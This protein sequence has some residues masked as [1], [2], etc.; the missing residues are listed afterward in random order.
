MPPGG[1]GPRTVSGSSSRP[2]SRSSRSAPHGPARFRSARARSAARS[3][4]G[5]ARSS[6]PRA[7]PPRTAGRS[8][9]G[10]RSC[11]PATGFPAPTHSS[12]SRAGPAARRSPGRSACRSS[13]RRR[14]R[15]ATSSFVDQRGTG[16]SNRLDCPLPK[17]PLGTEANAIRAYVKACLARFDA[18]V[19]QYTTAPA[20]EDVAEVVRAL[21]YEQVDVYGISYGATA[22]QYLLAQHPELVRTAI[23]DGGT[24]LDVPI[25]ELW[26]PNGERSLRS[27][28][29]RCA[30]SP[31]CARAY[32]R[33]RRE[34]FEMMATLR[35][36][37]VRASG[38]VIR[39][40]EA[41]GALQS[42][43]RTPAGAARIPWIAHRAALGDWDP[44]A[45][46]MDEAG[47]GGV[48][49][50]QL[51]FWSIVCNEPW[52]RWNPART[53]AGRPGHVP[54]RAHGGRRR[55]SR[56]SCA[57]RCRRPRS[58]P[59]RRRASA[60]TCRC[61]S[62]SAAATR[63]IRSR[64]SATPGGSCPRAAR[65]SSRTPGTVRCSSAV[66]P[67]SRS[68]SSRAGPRKAW[69]PAASRDTHRHRSSS[70]ARPCRGSERRPDVRRPVISRPRRGQAR[71]RAEPLALARQVAARDPALRRAR[72]PLDRVLPA[73]RGRVL[74]DPVHG[75]LPAVA[76]RLQ[77]RRPSLD[78][79][80][81]L[82]HVRRARDRPL[83][84]VHVE[85]R[86]GLPGLAR[87][88]VPRAPVAG[89]RPR[90]VVAARDPA[91]PRRRGVRG[92]RQLARVEGRAL[93]LDLGR[94]AHRAARP[95]RGRRLAVHRALPARCLRPRARPRPLGAPRRRLRGAHDRRLP[96]VPARP[97]RLG[98]RRSRARRGGARAVGNGHGSRRRLE[99]RPHRAARGRR[100]HRADRA[101]RPRGQAPRRS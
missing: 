15:P 87:R 24:L 6:S 45:I 26:A 16:A 3:R 32:P 2:R 38:V 56:G 44:L 52:A 43:T 30:T 40:A 22:A 1:C 96:A 23:L 13:S 92:R 47:T 58:R 90:E 60:R 21:G 39:P 50:G 100:A 83:S 99:R 5:A 98:A 18:D 93:G 61:C 25:F 94:R 75:P 82:L 69:T 9:C 27:I 71:G 88:R 49:T 77:R 76:L 74:R 48:A 17:K 72:V 36:S 35:R 68:S 14:T 33:V 63:R 4:P 95:D 84:A 10:S 67:G 51:M 41:A 46:T 19:R 20:M 42:L 66:R 101:R 55:R 37:P 53:R 29:S 11:P 97:G 79:A 8:G 86:R 78:V 81:R 31:R 64:T 57:R 7:A 73:Q 85:R 62:W 80:R 28:L 91:V 89:P 12:T 34:V 70:Y 54:R 65:S 59:G